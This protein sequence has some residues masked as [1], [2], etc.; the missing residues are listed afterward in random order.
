MKNDKVDW[1]TNSKQENDKKV[2]AKSSSTDYD[3]MQMMADE[4][5][6]LSMDKLTI[7]KPTLK[8]LAFSYRV[9]ED[10]LEFQS[11]LRNIASF[12]LYI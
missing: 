1:P 6:T 9:S 2:E 4:Y 7:H 5:D 8:D 11:G 10:D 12:C 3:V